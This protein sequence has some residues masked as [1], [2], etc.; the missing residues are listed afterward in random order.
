MQYLNSFAS[1]IKF[2]ENGD[3]AAMYDLVNWQMDPNGKIEFINIGKF[4]G[5]KQQLYIHEDIILWNGNQ[6]RVNSQNICRIC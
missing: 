6:T 1:E 2:D 5:V 4:D 3:P